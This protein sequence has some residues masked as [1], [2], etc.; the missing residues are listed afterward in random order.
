MEYGNFHA[1]LRNDDAA[2][3]GPVLPYQAAIGRCHID[4]PFSLKAAN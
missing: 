4:A 2:V 3:D 1:N